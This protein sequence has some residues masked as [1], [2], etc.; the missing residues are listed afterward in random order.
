M[1]KFYWT[2]VKNENSKLS[3]IN[4]MAEVID[5]R[6]L[7]F[8]VFNS[9]KGLNITLTLSNITMLLKDNIDY[10]CMIVLYDKNV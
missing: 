1:L 5:L 3:S 7:V 4:N 9:S 10:C 2:T 8:H 6:Q